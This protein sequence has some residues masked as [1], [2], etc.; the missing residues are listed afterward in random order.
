M[1]RAVLAAALAALSLASCDEALGPA[2]TA[3]FAGASAALPPV[4]G[5]ADSQLGPL[6]ETRAGYAVHDTAPGSTEA[7]PHHITGFA[8]GCARSVTAALVMFGDL[9]THE[10]TRYEAPE[11][12]Y[13]PVD[14]AYERIKAQACGAAPGQPCGADLD[15]LA[16][17]TVFVSAYPVFGEE[18]HRDLL[19]HQGEVVAADPPPS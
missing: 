9:A 12:A 13:S 3:A 16:R 18:A 10:V 4:C 14:A 2:P 11:G 19:L 1:P 8:D 17:D 7:R 6:V 5:L 15:Q